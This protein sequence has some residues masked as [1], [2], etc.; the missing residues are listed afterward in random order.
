MA[1]R[2]D[3]SGLPR[4]GR[5]SG[6]AAAAVDD[7]AIFELCRILLP[8][9]SVVDMAIVVVASVSTAAP[10][11]I[12]PTF[13]SARF[14]GGLPLLG[15]FFCCCRAVFSGTVAVAVAESASP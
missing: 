12:V 1:G 13:V 8:V 11:F 6:T 14:F 10:L 2:V 9:I 4:S 3:R 5:V 7:D 15:D